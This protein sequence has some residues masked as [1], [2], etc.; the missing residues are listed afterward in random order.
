VEAARD[1][2]NTKEDRD[3]E[4]ASKTWRTKIYKGPRYFTT[5]RARLSNTDK[6][7][8]FWS[9][10]NDGSKNVSMSS[11]IGG[12]PYPSRGGHH[13]VSQTEA[14]IKKFFNETFAKFKASG[15]K[16][17]PIF[18]EAIAEADKLLAELQSLVDK[19]STNSELMLG[20]AKEIGINVNKLNASKVIIAAERIKSGDIFTSQVV[21]GY[22]KRVRTATFIR[23]INQFG[24]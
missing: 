24:D 7:A 2:L 16:N 10:L 18:V 5:I 6:P 13:F 1:I 11:D 15:G 8:P 23:L 17:N 9:L 19:L 20:I 22:G 3:S 4:L 21:V 14:E 12:S